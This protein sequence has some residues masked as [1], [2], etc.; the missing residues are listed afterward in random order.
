MNI[1]GKKNIFLGISAVLVVASLAA[2]F[3]YGF[4]EG[5][6]FKGGTLWSI[7]IPNTPPTA[8]ALEK[9]FTEDLK[10]ADVHVIE[11]AISG[12]FLIKLPALNQADHKTI[13]DKLSQKFPGIEERSFQSIGPSVG[14]ELRKNS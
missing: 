14:A 7:S 11:E 4:R 5:I 3:I 12:N 1:I 10:L 13:F 9:F 8:S 6:D 2:I